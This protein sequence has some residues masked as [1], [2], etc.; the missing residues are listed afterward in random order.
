MNDT[1][2]LR[3]RDRSPL[4]TKLILLAVF[5]LGLAVIVMGYLG[6]REY[7]T[8]GFSSESAY[9][10]IYRLSGEV[11]T[12]WNKKLEPQLGALPEEKREALDQMSCDLL[13]A[14]WDSQKKGSAAA[15]DELLSE[16]SGSERTALIHRLLF[17]TYL[18]NGPKVSTAS[19]LNR[20]TTTATSRLTGPRFSAPQSCSA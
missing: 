10:A 15:L 7:S 19:R 3:K 17:S 1:A 2:L 6:M 5:L 13:T 16:K 12:A 14:A 8:S 20:G 4:V 18:V 11:S 9:R